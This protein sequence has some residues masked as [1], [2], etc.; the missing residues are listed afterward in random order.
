[1]TES[2]DARAVRVLGVALVLAGAL[3][4]LAAF[5]L[6]DWYDISGHAADSA[7]SVTFS[8]LKTS[9][10]QLGGAGVAIAY[11]D[12]LAWVLLIGLI[13]V[14]VAANVRTRLTDPLRVAGF[15]IGLIGAAATYYAL[16]QHFNATGS[17]HNVFYNSTWGVWAALVGFA[18]GGVGA[19]LGPG[20]TR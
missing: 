16:A 2:G 1:M 7:G 6:L 11:F 10:D 18:L 19:V 8:S 9:A 3:L 20:R 4:A 17:A 15:L 13:L 12:W 14:G 5:R